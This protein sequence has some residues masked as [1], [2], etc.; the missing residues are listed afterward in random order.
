M[1]DQKIELEIVLDDGS[2]KRAFATVR[3][4]ADD[5]GTS[6]GNAFRVQG[7]ADFKAGI[8]LVSIAL[9]ETK[10]IAEALLNDVLAGE[11]IDAINKRFEILAQQQ[12]INAE[13]LASGVARAVDGTV[14][15]EDA[16]DAAGRALINL[17]VGTREI[18]Q[19]FELARKAASA[20]GG[21]TVANFERIQQAILTGNTR[22]LREVGIFIN[23]EQAYKRLAD[24]IGTL[25]NN[26]SETGKQQAILNEVLRVGE[27][28][29]KNISSSITPVEKSL[30]VLA[31]S[32]GEVGDTFAMLANKILGP[33]LQGA[34]QQLANGFDLINIRLREFLLGTA[35]SAAENVRLLND[36]LTKLT[37]LRDQ[38]ANLANSEAE[39]AILDTQILQL[40]AKLDAQTQLA[41]KQA[42]KN[43]LDL[44]GNA[45]NQ[46][47]LMIQ[48]A[49]T[50]S[51]IEGR[52]ALEE[53]NKMQKKA[54]QDAQNSANQLNGAIKSALVNAIAQG[55]QA[56]AFALVKG[57]NVL[58]AFGKSILGV[59][60]DLAIQTGTIL[61]GIGLGLDS[62]FK[63]NGLAAVAAGIGL[64]AI[65]G[66]LKA[67]SGA[68]GGV[69]SGNTGVTA[70]GGGVAFTG[71][72]QTLIQQ[73][74]EQD[75]IRAPQTVVNF[76]VMGDILDSSDT[77]SRIVALLN[78]AIDTKGAV[79]RGV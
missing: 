45:I 47:S 22:A 54:A 25:P 39:V 76:Q 36:E 10:R 53:Y 62:L 5:A 1:A 66:I 51:Q 24:S 8:D 74:E 9:R 59:F 41:T 38:Q 2:V 14:D 46:E 49:L 28:R 27:E 44:Q 35:P 26:L 13:A 31:V 73:N 78:D 20:F 19:L 63:L 32:F 30:K 3:K 29:L 64:I 43:Q 4:E 69:P 55:V 6:F 79:I 70:D 12:A 71:D 56:M 50:Q 37:L 40:R 60:A 52:A 7:L 72:S 68:G 57:E 18:P 75:M 65:G 11:K 67:L 34:F 23:S 33:V 16:L 48:Q 17:Q 42:E 58:S 21:D 77:Q 15:M 61:I